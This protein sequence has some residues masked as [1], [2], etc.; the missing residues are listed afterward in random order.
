MVLGIDFSQISLVKKIHMVVT[1]D[2]GVEAHLSGVAKLGADEVVIF[3][4]N[5]EKAR[6]IEDRLGEM[7]L[8]YR[9][10]KVSG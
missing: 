6:L 3:E 1:G 9:S 8:G 10:I 2:E 7:G 5:S 4:L